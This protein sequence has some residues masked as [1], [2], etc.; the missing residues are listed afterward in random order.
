MNSKVS[1]SKVHLRGT[2]FGST[3]L[4]G[5]HLKSYL[6]ED[7]SFE[8]VFLPNRRESPA[9]EPDN[10][11]PRHIDFDQ[12]EQYPDLFK[13]DV[14]FICLGTTRKKAGSKAAF[15]KVD[16]D[17]VHR[18]AKLAKKY[19]CQ[20]LI[21]ISSL[22]ADASA[23]NFYLKTKGEAEELVRQN[24]PEDVHFLRPS[25][26]LGDRSEFRLGERIAQ[27]LMPLL[28]FLM[29]GKLKQ[30]QPIE[31]K[32]VARAMQILAKQAHADSVLLPN[33]IKAVVEKNQ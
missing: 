33:Q 32:V 19:E 17:L 10:L 13:V 12:L 18:I 14:I 22:G 20:K 6:G 8:Q 11:E 26:L 9:E 30:Y 5:S 24:G 3:G 2:I 15:Q 23:S 4:I 7:E 27:V 31:G 21:V 29:V 25:L 28:S 16:R 1:N